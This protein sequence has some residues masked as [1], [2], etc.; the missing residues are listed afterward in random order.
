[1]NIAI[2]DKVV[3]VQNAIWVNGLHSPCNGPALHEDLVV[4][5]LLEYK[6]RLFLHFTT[7]TGYQY[8]EQ[9]H[10]RKLDLDFSENV[11]RHLREIVKEE[12]R[13]F[14]NE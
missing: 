12:N 13:S 6:G 11:L 10:F 3:C 7:Y 2:N 5:G 8:F 4:D 14:S 1:M 9:K